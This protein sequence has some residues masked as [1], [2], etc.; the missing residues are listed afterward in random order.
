M[1][2]SDI[3]ER[4]KA[5]FDV[6]RAKEAANRF[7]EWMLHNPAGTVDISDAVLSAWGY[8]AAVAEVERLRNLPRADVA[9]YDR[10]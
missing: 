3:L 10:D 4:V 2:D 7:A 6:N 8:P 5:Q 1:S 9:A